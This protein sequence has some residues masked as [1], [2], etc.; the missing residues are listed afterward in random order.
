MP[1]LNSVE[2]ELILCVVLSSL[3]K[4]LPDSC[5]ENKK[6]SREAAERLKKKTTQLNKALHSC[7]FHFVSFHK[8]LLGS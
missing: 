6:R 2:N 4:V 1:V 7:S 3:T 8:V 5:T